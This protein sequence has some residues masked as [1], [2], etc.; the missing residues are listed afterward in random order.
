MRAFERK[1]EETRGNERLKNKAAKNALSQWIFRAWLGGV[2]ALK[3]MGE[4]ELPG[5]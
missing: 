5:L 2:P 3:V 1:R 4:Y